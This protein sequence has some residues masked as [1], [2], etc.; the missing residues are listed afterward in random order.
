M[1]VSSASGSLEGTVAIVT[2]GGRGLGRAMAR[3]LARAGCKVVVT[4]AREKM[5]VDEVAS[6]FNDSRVLALAADVTQPDDC[7]RVVEATVAQFGRLDVLVNNA[8]RGMKYIN[9]RF[10][11]DPTPFWET[12][13]TAWQMIIDTNVN[14]TFFMARAA[15]PRM[16]SQRWGR[17]INISANYATMQLPGFSPYGPSKAAVESLTIIW[18]QDLADT[19][20]TVNA[21]LPGGATLTGMVPASFPQAMRTSLLAPEVM[22][23]PLLW[24]ASDASDQTT[25]KRLIAK[26][27]R[28]DLSD[29]AATQA[30]VQNAGW[31][32]SSLPL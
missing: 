26:M 4:A 21:L 15:V 5:E 2:G 19:G 11:T 14:G 1:N 22:V 30:A 18:A 28:N 9:D 6:E 8:G 7:Q 16:L 17:I 13:P 24:L 27:W 10:M 31:A 29:T 12:N 3:G 32:V 20:V 25:G 23:P